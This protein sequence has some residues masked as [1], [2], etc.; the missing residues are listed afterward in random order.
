MW[1]IFLLLLQKQ[2]IGGQQSKVPKMVDRENVFYIK[3]FIN[4]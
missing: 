1:G 3:L 4:R 2:Y